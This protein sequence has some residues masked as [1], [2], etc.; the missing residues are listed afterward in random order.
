MASFTTLPESLENEMAEPYPLLQGFNYVDNSVDPLVERFSNPEV[1]LSGLTR[2]DIVQIINRCNEKDLLSGDLFMNHESNQPSRQMLLQHSASGR[3]H[4]KF[5]A[6]K[7]RQTGANKRIIKWSKL[8]GSIDR[9][10]A[11]EDL[12][13]LTLTLRQSHEGG[14]TD[15]PRIVDI[16]PSQQA[17]SLS[18]KR[19][20]SSSSQGATKDNSTETLQVN[21]LLVQGN[22]TIQG[23][24]TA[25]GYIH[26]DVVNGMG[27]D[28][29]EPFLYKGLITPQ[30]GDLVK[31]K[32]DGNINKSFVS[33]NTS[34]EG[35]LCVVSSTKQAMIYGGNITSESVLVALVG[36][37][38]VNV[39]IESYNRCNEKSPKALLT[40]VPS[41][42]HDGRGIVKL[43]DSE[44]QNSGLGIVLNTENDD[45]VLVMI[46]P[47]FGH[48]ANLIPDEDDQIDINNEPDIIQRID[49]SSAMGYDSKHA[50]LVEIFE[51]FKISHHLL[52]Q[53]TVVRHTKI[54]HSEI[55]R[56]VRE[57]EKILEGD[58]NDSDSQYIKLII[59]KNNIDYEKLL[60]IA[61]Q[62]RTLFQKQDGLLLN[63]DGKVR[64]RTLVG[65]FLQLYKIAEDVSKLFKN[66]SRQDLHCDETVL[67][68]LRG[69]QQE[70]VD[71]A[72]SSTKNAVVVIETGM[73]KTRIAIEIIQRKL[74]M[75]SGKCAVLLAPTR[76]LVLEHVDELSRVMRSFDVRNGNYEENKQNDTNSNKP[77]VWVMTSDK[78]KARQW[79]SPKMNDNEVS[80]VVLDECHSAVSRKGD[81]S[82]PYSFFLQAFASTSIQII[83]LT[84]T[85]DSGQKLIDAF[86]SETQLLRPTGDNLK[87]LK[88]LINTKKTQV[89][90]SKVNR[91]VSDISYS[92]SLCELMEILGVE[93][94]V[95]EKNPKRNKN[96]QI[97]R[98]A[99]AGRPKM[100][101]CKLLGPKSAFQKNLRDELENKTS[102]KTE[103]IVQSQINGIVILIKALSYAVR[104]SIEMGE[105][106]SLHRLLTP[107]VE[108][109]G[110][111]RYCM[112]QGN[113]ALVRKIL[114]HPVCKKILSAQTRYS[115]S[116]VQHPKYLELRNSLLAQFH[117]SQNDETKR[118]IIFVNYR[119]SAYVLK[120]IIKQD[121]DL[122]QKVFPLTCVGKGKG[123]GCCDVMN[124][125]QQQIAVQN[126]KN[127]DHKC[128][129]LIA[130]SVLY[131]GIDIQACNM[132]IMYSSVPRGV[133]L[134]QASGR[135]RQ[136]DSVTKIMY[137]GEGDEEE[138][139]MLKSKQEA[140]EIL[141]W[142]HEQENKCLN[143]EVVEQKVRHE[144][145]SEQKVDQVLAHEQTMMTGDGNDSTWQPK[146]N[147]VG[148]LHEFLTKTLATVIPKFTYDVP[149][150]NPLT[151]TVQLMIEDVPM[152]NRPVV[153]ANREVFELGQNI[154]CNKKTLKQYAAFL[155][156]KKIKRDEEA[157]VVTVKKSTK[158]SVTSIAASLPEIE[159][160]GTKL[161]SSNTVGTIEE[162]ETKDNC[163]EVDALKTRIAQIKAQDDYDEDDALM[164][165]LKQL[166]K[167][168]KDNSA[169]VN[170]LETR[171]AQIKAQD[172]YD[173]NDALMKELK[174]L[175]KRHRT[176]SPS[177]SIKLKLVP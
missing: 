52:T 117:S 70:V 90:Y 40:L 67:P 92:C 165:E 51:Q 98:Y 151:C 125:E 97:Q 42:K 44:L 101:D 112:E 110:R 16:Y 115:I 41:G 79:M 5:V 53:S 23:N 132:V 159:E 45:Q 170:A 124:D 9:T 163:A 161:P 43:F 111:I 29:A 83:G 109:I 171:I 18:K 122:Y 1:P 95:T 113:S 14:K 107:E 10:E 30:F 104:I 121:P 160:G 127:K 93:D 56:R 59:K 131:E 91:R 6:L 46:A 118:V 4:L 167:Q 66:G 143:D 20:T 28:V 63:V 100:E 27:L 88:E 138:R 136:A 62:A 68:P 19:K 89:V 176:I 149:I 21:G 150:G 50:K 72:L 141:E 94:Y 119:E 61:N 156:L 71:R 175:R 116:Q 84:A 3:K 65:H 137:Y 139:L 172:D 25:K 64:P 2:D 26:A 69:Y 168:V 166:R 49:D 102:S 146:I 152:E 74:R 47:S 15:Y 8:T 58:V 162:G 140:S 123:A 54:N 144:S 86:H 96:A 177:K 154:S 173:E 57:I 17:K 128:N 48:T 153:I 174:Q 134:L 169:E 106:A 34:G 135:A 36:Q 158:I 129:T 85:P 76:V 60:E 145:V 33:R 39:D 73:G 87:E 157:V 105:E 37:V 75:N 80:I 32:R 35:T 24:I 114:H 78:W 142:I 81:S 130:T 13:H 108:F 7:P 82:S 155:L 31:L 126:F 120:E 148:K 22:A 99:S 147:F 11:N 12:A 133:A 38:K 55:S 77:I 164:K 103:E